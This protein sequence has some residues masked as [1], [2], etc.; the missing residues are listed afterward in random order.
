MNPLHKARKSPSRDHT[1][2]QEQLKAADLGIVKP[3][4]PTGYE[5]PIAMNPEY[6]AF[7]IVSLDHQNYVAPAGTVQPERPPSAEYDTTDPD[8]NAVSRPVSTNIEEI[9]TGISTEHI[10]RIRPPSGGYSTFGTGL[11]S[12]GE[13]AEADD[14]NVTEDGHDY[15]Y[16]RT[17]NVNI[18]V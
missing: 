12:T 1:E 15:E 17:I 3:T 9:R 10:A 2:A 7:P 8:P 13:Y 14:G 18:S 5:Q 6:A 11:V 16:E 4:K